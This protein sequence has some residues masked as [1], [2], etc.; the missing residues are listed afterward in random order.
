VDAFSGGRFQ[1]L[2]QA[3]NRAR[4]L[5]YSLRGGNAVC[6]IWD[7]GQIV[8]ARYWIGS[9]VPTTTSVTGN[10][11]WVGRDG[12]SLAL[13]ELGKVTYSE[14]MRMAARIYAARTPQEQAA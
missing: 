12:Q 3:T 7:E 14:G 13:C 10:L 2:M 5:G 8:E 6:R 1:Q 11:V 4:S 9:D